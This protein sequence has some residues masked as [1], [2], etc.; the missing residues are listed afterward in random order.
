MNQVLG[1][2]SHIVDVTAQNFQEVIEQS[3]QT[4]VLLEFYVEGAEQCLPMA[5]TLNKLA[6]EYQ[7]KFV[8]GRIEAQQ[9]PQ[10]A[11]QLGVRGLPTVKVI[12]QGQMVQDLE[13]PQEE[14]TLR[15]ILDQ[16][17][18]SPIE[19]IQEQIRLLIEAGNRSGAI[20]LL[21]QVI[22]EEPA[23]HAMQVE[24]ADLLIMDN[25]AAEA[26]EIVAAI[27]ADTAGINK[28]INRLKFIDRAAD[29]LPL[30]KLESK[31]AA[32]V[33]DLQSRHQ[34]AIRLVVDD[35][36]EAALEHL[37]VMLQKDKTFEDELARKTMIEVFELLGKG[38]PVATAYR[39]KMFAFLH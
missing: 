9:N 27:P 23:N 7:G 34:L 36:I 13:G 1:T 22:Q 33:D 4:P 25:R 12:S 16:I 20:E 6:T 11:Q 26:R 39:R 14:A 31:V 19:R 21:Q 15:E 2:T 35:Q 18:M 5:A 17:T 29:L 38:D 28:P 24:L 10:V 3:K 37:L 32:D 30:S 8:L